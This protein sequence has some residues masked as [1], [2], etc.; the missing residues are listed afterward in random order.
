M[1]RP[2]ARPFEEIH[3]PAH[4]NGRA[5][6]YKAR[7]SWAALPAHGNGRAGPYKA[8]VSWAALPM[9]WAGP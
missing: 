1:G 4:G 2:V 8:R 6:P 5:G 7:V 3:G 9:S